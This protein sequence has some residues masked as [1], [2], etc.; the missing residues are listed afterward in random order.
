MN[1]RG[2]GGRARHG[3]AQPR[4]QRELS[5]L[6]TGGNQQ[7]ESNERRGSR[8]DRIDL[9]RDDGEGH[10][11]EGGDHRH[12]GDQHAHVADTVHDERLLGGDRVGGHVVPEADQQVG[13]QAHAFPTGKQAGVGISQDQGQHRRDEEIQVGEEAAAGRVVLHVGDRV[14]VDERTDEGHQDDERDRQ[15]V[16]EETK[17][18]GEVT[19]GDPGEQRLAEAAHVH[20]GVP[21]LGGD[22]RADH[23][24]GPGREGCQ[25]VA[26]LVRGASQQQEQA[27]ASQ[28]DEDEQPR[29]GSDSGGGNRVA[30]GE[31][32]RGNEGGHELRPPSVLQQVE[33]VHAR[34]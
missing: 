2:D 21:H 1:E 19:G 16:H 22:Q 5:G 17:V 7:E 23:E 3:I 29:V 12:H 32:L 30:D 15:R 8:G 31:S 20:G 34:G 14:H 25:Q 13:R 26:P 4:L 24:R 9:S 18:D 11:V 6:T 10:R 33:I 28:R 27:C